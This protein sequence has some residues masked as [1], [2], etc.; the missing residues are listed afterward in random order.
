[1][2]CVS[3]RLRS[4]KKERSSWPRG[5]RLDGAQAG[6]GQVEGS[7]FVNEVGDGMARGWSEIAEVVVREWVVQL[8]EML[9]RGGPTE[10]GERRLAAPKSTKGPATSIILHCRLSSFI[11][12]GEYACTLFI[13]KWSSAHSLSAFTSPHNPVLNFPSAGLPAGN[14]SNLHSLLS[15]YR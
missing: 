9:G 14:K 2:S 7:R 1:M 15:V 12:P 3:I 11:G 13:P 5:S 4:S 8:E 6:K 10:G